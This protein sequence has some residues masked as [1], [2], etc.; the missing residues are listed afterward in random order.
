M[1]DTGERVCKREKCRRSRRR[2]RGRRRRRRRHSGL[3]LQALVRGGGRLGRL[4]G[5]PFQTLRIDLF[6]DGS[7]SLHPLLVVVDHVLKLFQRFSTGSL[8]SLFFFFL[9]SPLLLSRDCR[10]P[11]VRKSFVF[12]ETPLQQSRTGET[13]SYTFD[14]LTIDI[15]TPII[16]FNRPLLLAFSPPLR[17]KTSNGGGKGKEGSFVIMRNTRFPV[18]YRV[19]FH[20]LRGFPVQRNLCPYNLYTY[21]RVYIYISLN[22]NLAR[23]F[24]TK[25]S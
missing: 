21:I 11:L 14:P 1:V 18:A 9:P 4:E 16:H 17:R 24:V 6:V 5:V 7:S 22:V 13:V 10:L 25:Y 8:L 23:D 12:T 15:S 3:L 19:L 2:R 20:S